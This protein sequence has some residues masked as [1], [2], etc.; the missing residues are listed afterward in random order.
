MR[1]HVPLLVGLASN[2]P[3]WFG[4]DSGLC[5]ARYV[6]SARTPGAA[7]RGRC[8]TSRT[9]RSSPRT[10]SRRRPA[11]PDLSLVGPEAAP[12]ARHARAARDG[13]AVLARA[14]GRDR[15]ARSRAGARGRGRPRSPGI[16]SEALD[17]ASFRAA[18]DGTDA[19]VLDGEITRPLADVARDAVRRVR[20]LAR[21]AG[22][23][24]AL[25]GIERVLEENGAARQCA[26]FAR[27]GC[28]SYC[29]RSP[30]RRRRRRWPPGEP[31]PAAANYQCAPPS[32]GRE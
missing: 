15:R 28:G 5:S 7:S 13:R 22:D 17:W 16:P 20:P 11:R 26:S 10:R 1:L 6:L 12:P 14:R 21:E 9:S 18:R 4:T 2:S 19:T 25:D 32:G 8:A 23:E 30:T 31:D 3:F 24:D 29:G 27:G